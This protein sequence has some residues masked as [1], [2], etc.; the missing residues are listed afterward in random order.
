MIEANEPGS[1]TS[2]TSF[3][4]V[5][6]HGKTPRAYHDLNVSGMRAHKALADELPGADWQHFH[7]SLEW[8]AGPDHAAHRA[9]V[10]RLISW[11]MPAEWI[12]PEE[13]VRRSPQVDPAAIG[14]A[15]VAFFIEDGWIDP[16]AFARRMI[17]EATTHGARVHTGTR[18]VGTEIGHGRVTGV[19]IGDGSIFY[20]D[21]VINCTGRWAGDTVF[22]PA[23]RV[24]LAPSLGLLVYLSCHASRLEHVL[25]TPRCHIRPDGA[26]R[27]LIGRNDAVSDLAAGSELR[28]DMP[29]VCELV[30][31][32]RKILPLDMRVE[33]VKLG[34]RAIPQDG[35]PMLG[36]WPGVEGYYVAVMHSGVTLAPAIGSLVAEELLGGHAQPMFASFRPERHQRV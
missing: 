7:G 2:G 25:H 23:L 9:N 29:E 3:A 26:G 15:P 14:D 5:N 11:G 10:E 20:A 28:P 12:S 21:A 17:D 24:P 1:G 30:N 16:V 32:A 31:D 8:R 35:F 6:S 34:I 27:L 33:S 36:W 18:V 4:W 22:P 13:A 19:Q